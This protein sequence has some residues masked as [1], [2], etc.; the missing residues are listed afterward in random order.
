[1]T[2]MAATTPKAAC[3]LTFIPNWPPSRGRAEF[4]GKLLGSACP[5]SLPAT[6]FFIPRPRRTRESGGIIVK[7]RLTQDPPRQFKGNLFARIGVRL[8]GAS[9]VAVSTRKSVQLQTVN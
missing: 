1:M 8:V 3:S 2:V 6:R 4:D 9:Q 7:I 5:L